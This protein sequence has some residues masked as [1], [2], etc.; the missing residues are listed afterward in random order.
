MVKAP[1]TTKSAP[2]QTLTTGKKRSEEPGITQPRL[3]I[4]RRK[5]LHLQSKP[6]T[7]RVS[8]SED[9]EKIGESMDFFNPS[10]YGFDSESP[11]T[12]LK[13]F[14]LCSK[15][16]PCIGPSRLQRWNRARDFGLDPPL[17]VLSILQDKS[18]EHQIGDKMIVQRCLWHNEFEEWKLFG[19]I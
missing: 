5:S 7:K 14:D 4:T 11:L 15:Y 2:K 17:D 1:Q 6:F 18:I 19:T 8:S 3:I 9:E 16:G 12:K 13:H 10:E